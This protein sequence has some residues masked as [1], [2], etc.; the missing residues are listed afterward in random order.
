MFIY[1]IGNVLNYMLWEDYALKLIEYSHEIFVNYLIVI[2][3]T[4][5]KIKEANGEYN[6]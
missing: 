6:N 3:L 5:A 2:V 1:C 4:H